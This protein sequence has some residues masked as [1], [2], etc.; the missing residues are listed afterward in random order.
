VEGTLADLGT[1]ESRPTR[2]RLYELI[3]AL[4]PTAERLGCAAELLSARALVE[5]N[6]AMRMRQV[7]AESGIP[8]VAAWVAERFLE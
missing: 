3:E 6:G 7:A 4:G 1:G 5:E 2:E 8:A